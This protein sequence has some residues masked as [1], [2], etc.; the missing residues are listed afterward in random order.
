M[1]SI[2]K[3]IVELVRINRTNQDAMEK[4]E[5]QPLRQGRVL[6]CIAAVRQGHG[7]LRRRLQNVRDPL[8]EL[9]L[10]S[11]RTNPIFRK[12]LPQFRPV[13]SQAGT[14]IIRPEEG[15]SI[16]FMTS[17]RKYTLHLLQRMPKSHMPNIVQKVS[18]KQ[19]V[20]VF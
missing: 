20:N 16:I 6:G 12:K 19:C 10:G 14:S 5:F 8:Q 13:L 18:K 3:K 2:S 7:W 17:A 4:T 9:V 1:M 15:Q 11:S